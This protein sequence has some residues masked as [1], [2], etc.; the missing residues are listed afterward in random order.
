LIRAE[1]EKVARWNEQ[2]ALIDG[3]ALALLAVLRVGIAYL[4]G[5]ARLVVVPTVAF[6]VAKANYVAA[7]ALALA[8]CAGGLDAGVC[9]GVA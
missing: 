3:D 6:I 1:E 2:H 8:G 5:A 9:G 4:P 7:L